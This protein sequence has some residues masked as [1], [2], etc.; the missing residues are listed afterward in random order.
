MT[1]SRMGLYLMTNAECSLSLSVVVFSMANELSTVS[2][3]NVNLNFQQINSHILFFY[4][5]LTYGCFMPT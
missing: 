4:I 2:I 1:S 3:F 5:L